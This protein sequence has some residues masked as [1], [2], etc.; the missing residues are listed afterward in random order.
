MMSKKTYVILSSIELFIVTV[1]FVIC[2][3]SILGVITIYWSLL[4]AV[5]ST[6]T[7]AIGTTIDNHLPVKDKNKEKE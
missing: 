4:S 1:A 3:L 7:M 2:L 5:I 6:S